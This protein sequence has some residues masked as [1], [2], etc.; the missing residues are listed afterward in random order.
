MTTTAR[1]GNNKY[2]SQL[3]IYLEPSTPPNGACQP[4]DSLASTPRPPYSPRTPRAP[5]C[6]RN[7][8]RSP[9]NPVAR[10]TRSPTA[11]RYDA[12]AA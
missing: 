2:P 11:L 3:A 4:R 8:T 6:G 7:N 1:T 12:T 5:L 10:A 9:A